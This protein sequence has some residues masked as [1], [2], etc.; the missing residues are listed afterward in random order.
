MEAGKLGSW[1]VGD[2]FFDV[3]V[4]FLWKMGKEGSWEA[5]KKI[6]TGKLILE[7][8]ALLFWSLNFWSFEF[9]SNFMFHDFVLRIYSYPSADKPQPKRLL[10]TRR[11]GGAEDEEMFF[12]FYYKLF[13]SASPRLRVS[14][15]KKISCREMARFHDLI[16]SGILP[17]HHLFKKSDQALPHHS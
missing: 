8:H 11:R 7:F 2:S 6:E 16:I 5:G 9:V 1:E 15:C 13:Y 3:G 10:L 14:A 12:I 17:W 4:I